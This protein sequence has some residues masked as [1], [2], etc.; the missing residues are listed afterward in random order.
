MPFSVNSCRPS[1]ISGWPF[2]A[3]NF[4][5][6]SFSAFRKPSGVLMSGLPSASYISLRT[7]NVWFDVKLLPYFS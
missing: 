6:A 4:S 5:F 7:T 1:G 3:G 2:T